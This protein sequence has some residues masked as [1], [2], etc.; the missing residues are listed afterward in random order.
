MQGRGITIEPDRNATF[1]KEDVI[2]PEFQKD[3]TEVC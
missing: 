2:D 1:G 3:K